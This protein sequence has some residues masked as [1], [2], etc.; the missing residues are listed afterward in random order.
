VKVKISKKKIAIG[1]ILIIMLI[2]IPTF[3]RYIYN[4]IRDAY[5][6]SRNFSFSSNLLTTTGGNY[7]YSNWSGV[8]NYELNFQLYSY[9]N[10][11]SLFQYEGAGLGYNLT[12]TID[13]PTKATA[14]IDYTSGEASGN[15]YIPNDTNIR[16]VK[17]YLR[18]TGGLNPGDIIKLTLEAKTTVPFKK[19]IKATFE[20]KVTENRISYEIEDSSNSVY[21]TLKLLNAKST[22]NQIKLTF[23]PNVVM[24]DTSD[25]SYINRDAQTVTTVSGVQYVNSVTITLDPE[26]SKNIKF[27]KRDRSQNYTYPN[28][29]PGSSMIIT[30]TQG[31]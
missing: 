19:T 31:G 2:T 20:I 17:V 10:E 21:A 11:I 15:S 14:H 18:P 3:G 13:Q 29:V 25:E 23:N 12:C 5:L 7:K 8:E 27:Y 22:E 1:I 26:V 30:I 16:D 24:I 28:G 4:N 9:E 6:K